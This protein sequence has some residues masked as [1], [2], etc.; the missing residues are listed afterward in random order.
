M[1]AMRAMR[2][3]LLIELM[4]LAKRETG[5]NRNV[6]NMGIKFFLQVYA[7]RPAKSVP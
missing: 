5:Q 4:W 2:S 7:D 6:P 1:G 3:Q